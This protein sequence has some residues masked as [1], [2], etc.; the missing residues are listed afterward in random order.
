MLILEDNSNL[1]IKLNEQEDLPKKISAI[2]QIM[3]AVE[4]PEVDGGILL[5]ATGLGKTF[6]AY[7]A[8]QRLRDINPGLRILV[9]AH[10][11]ELVYQLEQD[12]SPF[13][14]NQYFRQSGTELKQEQ[15]L[16]RP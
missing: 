6:T 10:T 3:A 9:V 14:Q 11:N 13:Y 2:D 4:E 7:S 1:D 15:L 12:I 5:L 8:V 16:A